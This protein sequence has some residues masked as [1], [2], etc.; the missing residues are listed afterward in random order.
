M[1]YTYLLINLLTVFFP[2]VLSFDKRVRFYKSWKFIWPGMAVTGL[3][4]L[5]WDVLFTVRGV[6]SFNSAYIIGVKFFGLPLEEIL[7]FLTVPFACIFIY[8]CLN[9]YVKWLMPFRLTGIISSMVILLSIL[10]LI[11]YHDRL[12]TAVTFGLLLLLVVL[13][14]YVFKADWVNR[15]YLAYI[16]A[17][18]PFYIV[19]GILT[20]VPI[21]LYNNAENLGK[22]VGT[23]P[24][25]DHFYLMA[26]L[27]MNIG[28][29]EYFK[30]QRLSR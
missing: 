12:Y 23:I 16:V 18:L 5:F 25:E 8:A 13:I 15:Y 3:F 9:H 1:R 10:M 29:F 19:N 22:R 4:F 14:Q 20:S 26:L 21:V 28:F 11:F 30:Q 24:F 7:F 27:L 6:W 17:L 2:V